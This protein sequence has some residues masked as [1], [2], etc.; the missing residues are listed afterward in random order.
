MVLRAFLDDVFNWLFY[1]LNTRKIFKNFLC[2]VI[3][4]MASNFTSTLS[5]KKIWFA[6]RLYNYSFHIKSE[7]FIKSLNVF[8]RS[9]HITR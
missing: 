8:C 9:V 7:S 6:F 5:V 4:E 1:L 2:V 3:G